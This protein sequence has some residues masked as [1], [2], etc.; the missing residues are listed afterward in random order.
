VRKLNSIVQ[1]LV[2]GLKACGWI[3]LLLFLVYYIFAIGAVIFF[4]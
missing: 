3:G 1:G 2:G 4:G